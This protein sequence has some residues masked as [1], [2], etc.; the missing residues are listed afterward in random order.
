MHS[1]VV[2]VSK[3]SGKLNLLLDSYDALRHYDPLL[4]TVERN[5][6]QKQC[7]IVSLLLNSWNGRRGCR[8]RAVL[9]CQSEKCV[10]HRK[11]RDR[12]YVRLS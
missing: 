4:N 5:Q 10:G 8:T 3:D 12:K 6:L 9:S 1:P 11:R 7:L 2:R